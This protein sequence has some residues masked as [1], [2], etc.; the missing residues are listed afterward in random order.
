MQDSGFFAPSL[1]HRCTCN[2]PG[3]QRLPGAKR[4][5]EVRVSST[6]PVAGRYVGSQK[7]SSQAPH[8]AS[9]LFPSFAG[10]GRICHLVYP[11]SGS[12]K[13]WEEAGGR[14]GCRDW[15]LR[16]S[17]SRPL[18]VGGGLSALRLPGSA[19]RRWGRD[20]QPLHWGWCCNCAAA[21][22]AACDI[23]AGERENPS[24][25]SSRC[26]YVVAGRCWLRGW[27]GRPFPLDPTT[28]TPHPR[29]QVV[30]SFAHL[31]GTPAAGRGGQRSAKR[32]V[33]A[34][35]APICSI[36]KKYIIFLKEYFGSLNGFAA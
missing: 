10:S 36:F 19:L 11:V 20:G 15:R 22:A 33:L 28:A 34:E 31:A 8:K 1:T 16:G 26:S 3:V 35:A 21:A 5:L 4:K 2:L 24:H 23:F 32:Q 12:L 17:L 7:R 9:S 14:A 25:V 27:P 29:P 6:A 18:S 30:A 13:E